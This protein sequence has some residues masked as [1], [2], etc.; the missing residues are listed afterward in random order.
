[1]ACCELDQL[2]TSASEKWIGADEQCTRL[3]AH[4][5]VEGSI[6]LPT[7]AGVE[8]HNGQRHR[9]RRGLYISQRGFGCTTARNDQHSKALGS[10][11]QFSHQLQSLCHQLCTKEIDAC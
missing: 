6:N 2:D 7:G 9:V 4:K 5:Y 10:G 8:S 11:H 3:L 1:M